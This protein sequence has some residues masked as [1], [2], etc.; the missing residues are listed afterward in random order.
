MVTQC[1]GFGKIFF[2]PPPGSI[3]PAKLKVTLQQKGSA[4]ATAKPKQEEA[5]FSPV[6]I[7]RLCWNNWNPARGGGKEGADGK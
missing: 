7:T 3:V 1:N 6:A 4:S 2:G 5:L